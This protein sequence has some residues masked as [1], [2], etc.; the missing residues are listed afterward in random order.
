MDGGALSDIAEWGPRGRSAS[1]R[2]PIFQSTLIRQTV[3]VVPLTICALFDGMEMPIDPM[4]A[5]G[6]LSPMTTIKADRGLP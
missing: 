4:A 5:L 2:R 3:I 6:P 1:L